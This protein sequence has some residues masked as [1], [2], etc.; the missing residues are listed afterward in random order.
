MVIEKK[1]GIRNTR[2]REGDKRE[3]HL[4]NQGTPLAKADGS[5]SNAL[6]LRQIKAALWTSVPHL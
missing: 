5:G 2:G 1:N 3:Q 6:Y 4:E